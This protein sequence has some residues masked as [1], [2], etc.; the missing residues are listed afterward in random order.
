MKLDQASTRL[1]GP[2]GPGKR[3]IDALSTPEPAPLTSDEAQRALLRFRKKQVG[4]LAGL[5]GLAGGGSVR[6]NEQARTGASRELRSANR[7]ARR[8]LDSVV[9][10]AWVLPP[11]PLPQAADRR[12]QSV[13]RVIAAAATNPAARA[14]R[15]GAWQQVEFARHPEGDVFG[16]LLALMLV[17]AHSTPTSDYRS[18]VKQILARAEGTDIAQDPEG[19][20]RWLRQVIVSGRERLRQLGRPRL[21]STT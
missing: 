15:R 3:V 6:G 20:E 21:D 18:V 1:H 13:L 17:P 4:N 16:P 9:P 14:T 11:A 5:A 19:T 12:L 2:E 10:V 7:V 8:F